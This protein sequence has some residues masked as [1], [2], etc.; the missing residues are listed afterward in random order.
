MTDTG[1]LL[2]PVDLNKLIESI[3]F[4][5]KVDKWFI[6]LVSNI[7]K[8]K[9]FLDFPMLQSDLNKVPFH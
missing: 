5:P 3:Y 7:V 9:Y 2:V 1:D 6:K 4:S 8:K